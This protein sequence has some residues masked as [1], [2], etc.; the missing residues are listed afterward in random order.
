MSFHE[1]NLAAFIELLI[2]KRS[3]RLFSPQD[4]AELMQLIDPLP[5]DIEQLSI[6]IADWY[7]NRAS[8]LDA[9]LELLNDLSRGAI[10]INGDKAPGSIQGNVPEPNPKLNKQ[11]LGNSIQNSYGKQ[12]PPDKNR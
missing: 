7:E 6:A 10:R 4:R 3:S 2:D 5:D 1:Q 11:M 12:S 9:Q 8:I